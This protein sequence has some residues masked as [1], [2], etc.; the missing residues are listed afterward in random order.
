LLLDEPSAGLAPAIVGEVYDTI[1]QLRDE[2]LAVLLVE[3]AVGWAASVADRIA[4]MSLGEKLY[5]GPATGPQAE[6]AIRKIELVGE[7]VETA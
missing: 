6:E 3:Q 2:G 5:E 7:S 4:V 1:A